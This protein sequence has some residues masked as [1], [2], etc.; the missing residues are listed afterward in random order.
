MNILKICSD[1][2][3]RAGP[4]APGYHLELHVELE[5]YNE[6]LRANGL[7]EKMKDH[8]PRPFRRTDFILW[9]LPIVFDP[10]VPV[11]RVAV[12]KDGSERPC[13]ED[14]GGEQ[15]GDGTIH[16]SD[17]DRSEE[18]ADAMHEWEREEGK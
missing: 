1:T 3:R 13:L 14:F 9:G 6:I 17:P 12:V 15:Q 11:A 2:A 10:T 8:P 5:A 4:P 18:Y 7:E 16:W